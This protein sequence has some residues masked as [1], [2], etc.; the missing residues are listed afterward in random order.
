MNLKLIAVGCIHGELKK[1]L[2]DFI[3]SEKP[4]AVLISGDFSGGQFDDKLRNYEKDIVDKF[5]PISEF[6]PLKVQIDSEKNF[7]KWGRMSAQNTAKVFQEL[8]KID[9]PIFYI[10]G[11]WDSVSMGMKRIF[12]GS[13]NFFVDDEAGGNMRFIHNKIVRVKDFQ[14][15]GFG[16]YRGTSTKEYLYRDLPEPRPDLKYIIGIRDEMRHCLENLFSRV[17][18]KRKTILLTHDPPYRLFDYLASAKKNYGEKI[19]RDVIEKHTPLLCLCS[20]FHE[21]Q[22]KGRIK[23]TVVV[24]SGF[25]REGQCALIE[26]DD[27]NVPKVTLKKL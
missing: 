26:I 24:N 1:K 7:Q 6:W 11:N 22:G 27:D 23:N 21:H 18:D 17:K 15:I 9:V 2:S 12:E 13:G 19:T 14:I 10:H 3:M 25:G 16:G 5:G 4:D 8:K 20:H